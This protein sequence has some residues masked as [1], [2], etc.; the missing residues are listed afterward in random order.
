MSKYY[1]ER[2]SILESKINI[3]YHELFCKSDKELDDWIEEVRQ[4]IIEEW[5]ERGI[6]PMVGQ[7]IADITN[8]FRKLREYDIHGFIEKDD[9]GNANVIKNFNKFA[10]GVN[11]FFPTMVKTRIGDVG[12]VGLNSIYDRIKE[13]VNKDLFYKAMRR[14]VR[15][16]SMYS[17]SK[18]LSLDRKENEQGKKIYWDGESATDWLKYYNDNKLKFSKFRIWI[19]KSHQEKYLKQY[20]TIKAEDIRLAHKN[21]LISDEMLTNIWCPTLKKKISLDDLTDTVMTKGGNVKTNVFMIRYYHIE[22]KLYPSA[23]Q[24]FRLSL[25]SQPAVNFPPLTARLLYEKY[26]DHIKQDTPL[27]IYD[28]SSGWGGRILGAMSSKKDIHYIG[29]D[30]N[31]D[32]YIDELGKSRYEYVADFFNNEALETNPFWEEKRNTYHVFQEGSEHIGEHPDFQQYKGKLDMVFTSPPYFDREQYSEDEE[33]SFKAYPMYHDWRDNFLKPTLTNAYE[34]LKSDRYLLWNIAS[35]KIGKDRYHPLEED[36]IEIVKSLGGEYKGKLKMLMS[37]MI[38]VDQSN[39]KNSV[40]VDGSV[41][42]YEPIFIFYK[43]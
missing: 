18:S 37:S 33:Q 43:G 42:K 20:V 3:T 41:S 40:K 7:S 30:P 29:T 26:T 6:P 1:Y 14:G 12:D 17:F 31:T 25:N 32:N 16:D 34:S 19:S 11:Q 15:R 2:S 35:I 21:G 8:G 38:G 28:P 10:N 5:D 4:Y 9:D 39:V 36:S 24:I 13:D 23:F 27:N 22:K